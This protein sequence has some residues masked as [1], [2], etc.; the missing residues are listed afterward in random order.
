MYCRNCRMEVSEMAY[1]CPNCGWHPTMGRNYCYYCGGATNPYAVVCV[2]CGVSLQQPEAYGEPKSKLIAGLLGIFIGYLG[3]HNFYLGFTSK[4]GIQLG[5]S[6]LGFVLIPFTWGFSMLF[7][8]AAG[9][10]AFIEAIMILTGNIST[11]ARG[12]RLKD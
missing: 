3:I 7:L 1:A 4:G 2:T 9:L 11:D 8:S 10:W 12:V 6:L 5:L